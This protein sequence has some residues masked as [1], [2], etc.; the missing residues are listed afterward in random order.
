M[1]RQ[2]RLDRPGR[3]VL[4]VDPQPVAACARRS[5]RSRPRRRSRGRPSSTSRRAGGRPR[6]PRAGSSPRSLPRPLRL[7][8][9]PM[10]SPALSSR[11]SASNSAGGHSS[12]VSGLIDRQVDPVDRLAQRPLGHAEH[13]VDRRAALALAVALDEVAPEALAGSGPGR[14]PTP[15][16]RRRSAA[17]SRR[18][19]VAPAWPGCR[20]SP[21]RRS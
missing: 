17:C 2:H 21:C 9:S 13:R 10:A 12:P 19:R 7:T 1:A 3:E 16:C 15:R 5:R 18:R 14:A 6:R 11:P 4:R 20:R 8:I